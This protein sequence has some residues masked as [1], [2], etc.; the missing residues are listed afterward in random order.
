MQLFPQYIVFLKKSLKSQIFA[1]DPAKPSRIVAFAATCSLMFWAS[2]RTRTAN[3][4][5]AALLFS[6]YVSAGEEEYQRQYNQC[7]CSSHMLRL[8]PFIYGSIS[9]L[10][11]AAAPC[12]CF[13]PLCSSYCSSKCALTFFAISTSA[14]TMHASAM[15]PGTKPAAKCPSVKSVPN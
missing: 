11:Y 5:S 4:R 8:L 10:S 1:L 6:V 15:S 3:A 12:V 13:P 7:Y 14:A 2:S 9:A